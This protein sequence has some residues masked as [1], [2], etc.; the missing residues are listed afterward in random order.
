[1]CLFDVLYHQYQD[2]M[3]QIY[4]QNQ[5]KEDD[6]VAGGMILLVYICDVILF[7]AYLNDSPHK[8]IDI[9]YPRNKGVIP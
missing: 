5:R 9:N 1:M 3:V 7:D 6:G 8:V 2:K 4:S